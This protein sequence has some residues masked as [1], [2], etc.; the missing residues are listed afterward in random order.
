MSHQNNKY[1]RESIIPF[2]I[3]AMAYNTKSHHIFTNSYP[4]LTWG[5]FIFKNFTLPLACGVKGVTFRH[6]LVQTTGPSG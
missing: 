3:Q 6:R 4:S 1:N 5:F 2:V